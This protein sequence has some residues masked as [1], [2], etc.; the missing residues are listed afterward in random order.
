MILHDTSAISPAMPVAD[1]D[2]SGSMLGTRG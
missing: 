2:E 1:T